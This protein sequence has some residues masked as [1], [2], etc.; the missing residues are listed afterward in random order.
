MASALCEDRAL[1]DLP[2]G[3]FSASKRARKISDT[4]LDEK[5]A[6]RSF[7]VLWS[8]K[9]N[10]YRIRRVSVDNL[11]LRHLEGT[12]LDRISLDAEMVGCHG[13]TSG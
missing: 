1:E 5:A 9:R 4:Y 12:L 13:P 2:D 11:R 7:R 6:E 8:F 3:I 10:G